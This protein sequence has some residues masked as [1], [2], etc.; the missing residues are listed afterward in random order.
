MT[1]QRPY[2][3]DVTQQYV[4]R[5]A[6]RSI[7]E[8]FGTPPMLVGSCLERADFRD[9]DLR[10]MMDDA[11]F[12]ALFPGYD[13]SVGTCARLAFLNAAISSY[14]AARTG[15][16]IDFQFQRRT[17]ANE[18]YGGQKRNSQFVSRACP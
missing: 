3:L 2:Y 12:D 1:K 18:K 15:L 6:C 7:L 4:L 13:P 9:V 11:E 10:L 14:L 5:H 16:P 17:E 8:S